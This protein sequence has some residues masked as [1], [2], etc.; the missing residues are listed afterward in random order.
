MPI[1]SDRYGF[2]PPEPPITMREGD[3]GPLREFIWSL[4]LKAGANPV[5]L[6][7]LVLD[8]VYYP[9]YDASRSLIGMAQDALLQCPWHQ[10]YDVAE[11]IYG[12]LARFGR[13]GEDRFQRDLNTFLRQA[14]IGWQMVLGSVNVRGPETFEATVHHA[15]DALKASGRLTSESE[16][17]E[18]SRD[19]SRRPNPDIT[20]AVQHAGAALEC[21]ARD[22]T[23]DPKKTFGEIL[24]AY[25]DLFPRPLDD[26]ATKL[27]GFVS[28]YGRH[29]REGHAPTVEEALLI[30]GIAASLSGFIA[31]RK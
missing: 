19:L 29:V 1:F 6:A 24:K 5:D 28:N 8:T 26:A 21:V 15:A 12:D 25:P 10:V 4:A 18:A 20:G 14:G 31:A 13:S 27:W 16:L 9:H 2:Q 22:V 11:Q 30:L 3:P 23:G 17:R 7:Q